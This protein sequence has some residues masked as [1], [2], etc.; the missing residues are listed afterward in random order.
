MKINDFDFLGLSWEASWDAFGPHGALLGRLRALL[1]IP[2]AIHARLGTLAGRL[3]PL[4]GPFRGN[5]QLS[6][7]APGSS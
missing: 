2:E 3:G 4:L 6:L 7:A 1:A 5:F